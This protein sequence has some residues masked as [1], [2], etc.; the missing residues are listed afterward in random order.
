MKN[1]LHSASNGLGFNE[2]GVRFYV[3]VSLLPKNPYPLNFKSY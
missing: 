1:Y 3:G 2:I